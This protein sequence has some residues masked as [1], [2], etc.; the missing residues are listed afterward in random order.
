MRDELLAYLLNDLDDEQRARVEERLAADPIW[1]HEL[2]RLRSYVDA[3]QEQQDDESEPLPAD[4]VRRTCSFV[5]QA[6]S[7]GE[8]SP[9]V[10]PAKLSESQDA[11]APRKTRWTLLDLTVVASILAIMASLVMPAIRES[12]ESARRMQCQAQLR[13]LGEALTRFAEQNQGQLPAIELNENAG[14]FAV[15][16]LESGLVTQEELSEALVCPSGVLADKVFE[17]EVEMRVP[18]REELNRSNL[19]DLQKFIARMGG[20]FAFR[21]GFHDQQGN[22]RQVEFTGSSNEPMMADKPSYEVAGFQSPHHGTCGQNVLF[23]DGSVRYVEICI[24]TGPDKHWFLNEKQ[25][26]AAGTQR[27]DIVM[28]RSEASP[29]GTI[30]LINSK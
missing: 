4:L 23:Q 7:Q 8:L 13:T 29:S 18:T 25:K 1:Q 27:F 30:T 14:M 15:K 20:S 16:L 26:H 9:K 21:I 28:G 24:Q 10:L 3:S 17:G 5:K 12:R 6:S 19:A 2:E 11:S 22:Y